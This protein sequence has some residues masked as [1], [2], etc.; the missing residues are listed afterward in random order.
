MAGSSILDFR[1][2]VVPGLHGSGPAHWQTRW[3]R[4]FPYFE[5]VEQLQWDVPD[6]HVWSDRL[7][8]VLRQSSQPAL[9]VA[10]SFG[11][12]AAVHRIGKGAPTVSGALL[13]GPADPEKFGIFES[14]R[15]V[16]MPIP[17]M[18][19]ASSTDPWM[20]IRNAAA[21]AGTWGSDFINVGALGHIN[22]DS[23]LGDWQHGLTLLCRLAR[24][25]PAG[26]YQKSFCGYTKGDGLLRISI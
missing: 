12:L 15:N 8:K 2:L 9:I 26:S 19:V 20:D 24:S 6:L 14:V 10:H 5:R 23:G 21:W 7:D 16:R 1:I 17:A 3:Q 25:V 22:A 11:C 13:V 4:L 18:L